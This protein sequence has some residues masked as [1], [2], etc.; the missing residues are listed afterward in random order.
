MKTPPIWILEVSPLPLIMTPFIIGV[1]SF[2]PEA[3]EDRKGEEGSM[4][5]SFRPASTGVQVIMFM[6]WE[7]RILFA[8]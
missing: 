5:P 7:A 3:A 2:W 1:L 4:P 6:S 8:S